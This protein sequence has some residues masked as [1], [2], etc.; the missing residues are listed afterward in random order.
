MRLKAVALMAAVVAALSLSSCGN[1]EMKSKVA[2][3]TKVAGE[4]P[5]NCTDTK[6]LEALK[7]IVPNSQFIDTHW[8]AAAGSDLGE[9][10]DNAGIACSYGDQSVEIGV[11]VMW[12]K[13]ADLFESRITAWHKDGQKEIKIDGAS[14]AFFITQAQDATHEF[15]RWELNLLHNGI[16][17]NIKSTMG[18]TKSDNSSIVSAAI[19]SVDP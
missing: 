19:E 15:H 9:V 8:A 17:I 6:I 14:Q 4:V 10:L 18:S 3:P 11:T 1:T 16:W 2:I 5:L 13:G 7:P 12:V